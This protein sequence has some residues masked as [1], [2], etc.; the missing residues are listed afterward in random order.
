MLSIASV[1]AVAS[2][3]ASM[4]GRTHEADGSNG[5]FLVVVSSDEFF[6]FGMLHQHSDSG[7]KWHANDKNCVHKYL[8]VDVI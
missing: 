4:L 6:F 7:F 2:G 5:D 1:E 8:N 3:S